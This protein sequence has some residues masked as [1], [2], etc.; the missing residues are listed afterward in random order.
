MSVM[1]E[2]HT[3]AEV[4]RYYIVYADSAEEA[5]TL[6]N[7]QTWD[8]EVIAYEYVESVRDEDQLRATNE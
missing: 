7:D 3:I 6:W 5:A 2:V 4:D 8:D 1:F